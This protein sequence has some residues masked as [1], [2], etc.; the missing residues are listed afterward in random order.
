MLVFAGRAVLIVTLGLSLAGCGSSGG[1]SVDGAAAPHTGGSGGGN[2]GTGGAPGNGTGGAPATGGPDASAMTSKPTDC[3]SL[4][5][6][7]D[8]CGADAACAGRCIAAAPAAAQTLYKKIHDCSVQACPDQTMTDCR[9][10]N[11]CYGNGQCADLVDECDMSN[12]DFFCDPGGTI[13]GI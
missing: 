3:R 9:C 4:L 8:T 1:A 11:E 12:P 13:C 5:V 7:V 10:E 2:P 6:C